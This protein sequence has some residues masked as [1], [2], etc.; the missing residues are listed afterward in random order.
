[1]EDVKEKKERAGEVGMAGPLNCARHVLL[2][3]TF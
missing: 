2:Y 3:Q 1:M